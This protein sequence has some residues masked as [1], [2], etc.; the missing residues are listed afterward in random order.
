MKRLTLSA[1]LVSLL[2][3]LVACPPATSPDTEKPTLSVTAPTEDATVYA[4]K[5][6]VK[7]TA[8]DNTAVTKLTIQVNDAAVQDITSSLKADKSFMTE[9][10]LKQGV[11]TIVVTAL[12]AQENSQK[13]TRNI[14]LAA[15]K[16]APKLNITSPAEG[17]IIIPVPFIVIEGT[18][19]DNIGITKFTI[20]VNGVVMDATDKIVDGKF[21]VDVPLQKGRNSLEISVEDAAGNS[22]GAQGR[23]I[24]DDIVAPVVA[25]TSPVTDGMTA[26]SRILTLSG[27]ATDNLAVTKLTIQV[28]D[29]AAKDVF[30][31]L[32]RGTFAIPVTLQ[33][34]HNVITVTAMDAKGHSTKAV[35]SITFNPS[36]A[37]SIAGRIWFDGNANGTQ[38]AGEVSSAQRTVFLDANNN[39]LLD[40]GE[41][42]VKT[43]ANGNYSFDNLAAG[44]Y[45]VNQVL[46]FGERFATASSSQTVAVR[47]VEWARSGRDDSRIVGGEDANISDFP[48]M[49][50]LGMLGAQNN[51]RQF[52]GATLITAHHAV[53]AAHCVQGHNPNLAV[54]L[55]TDRLD[56]NSGTAIR[57][58]KVFSHPRFSSQIEA[59]YDIAVLE[60]ATAVDLSKHYTVEMLDATT[61]RFTAT[62]TVATATGWGALAS[63]SRG[64]PRLQVVH[65]KIVDPAACK[66]A[67][68][69]SNP[70]NFETQLC[71]GVPE[72]GVDACQGDSGGPL[73]VRGDVNGEKRWFHAGATSWGNGC[74]FAGF[75]GIWARIS[76]LYPWIV[77]HSI[78]K[79]SSQQVVLTD[80][81]ISN[82][83]F[84]NQ[85]AFRPFIKDIP[86][87]WQTTAF[88]LK[89][90]NQGNFFVKP[91][92]DLKFDWNIFAEEGAGYSY[93][94]KFA[95]GK[96]GASPD[97][98]AVPC[99][100]GANSYTL[101]GGIA[102]GRR[103]ISLTVETSNGTQSRES[104]VGLVAHSLDGE[105]TTTDSID[106]DYPK[107]TYYIDYVELEGLTVG[108]LVTLVVDTTQFSSF[109]VLFDKAERN[110]QTGGGDLGSGY[111]SI[112]FK[113]EA[114]INY[115][116]GVSSYSSEGVGS[117]K[118]LTSQGTLKSYTFP[119]SQ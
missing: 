58:S 59:G 69:A 88:S 8:D 15:D 9:V 79:S 51:F 117:Y 26:S 84:A 57:V 63:G 116:V 42:H 31:L 111:S 1:L 28:N 34:N 98:R 4:V 75:P 53:T 43:D 13:L 46:T 103:D 107:E 86:P 41:V 25:I 92:A 72:G 21:R 12:D 64:T 66:K 85:T 47:E 52:C 11:N 80:S 97:V 76:V 104:R 35:R 56:N 109:M 54:L 81:S 118:L 55:G 100:L 95:V 39:G 18:A 77:E 33:D 82:I 40:A 7:G 29:A 115:L 99:T 17:N 67:Y 45:N 105:L 16:E 70:S 30:N 14:T 62:D 48:F 50:A 102:E 20:Q 87:R 114:D 37:L 3:L 36:A 10:T 119:T 112:T 22:A 101:R 90:E 113:V 93:T 83:N 94:C 49:L 61:E 44:T 6:V 106:P 110:P 78:A 68:A 38:D 60:L 96:P 71:A 89:S 27:T 24:V 73:F 74:A 65:T 108:E 32:D 5:L 19:T 2:V 91:N 23:I